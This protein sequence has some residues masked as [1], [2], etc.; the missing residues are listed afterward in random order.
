M[1]F[2]F[3]LAIWRRIDT[4]FVCAVYELV[5][6]WARFFSSFALG[7]RSREMAD[8]LQ[9]SDISKRQKSLLGDAK[10]HNALL[11]SRARDRIQTVVLH[12]L[13]LA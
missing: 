12:V 2:A 10:E 11:L 5:T 3:K 8:D 13:R 6:W 9:A 7:F 4:F 1:Q